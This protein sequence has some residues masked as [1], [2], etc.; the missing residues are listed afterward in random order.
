[1]CFL[2]FNL[3]SVQSY[4]IYLNYATLSLFIFFNHVAK[5]IYALFNKYSKRE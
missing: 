1:M 4:K 3:K 5:H 2:V